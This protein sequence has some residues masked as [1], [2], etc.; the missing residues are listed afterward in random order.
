MRRIE[1]SAPGGSG[2]DGA[3]RRGIGRLT[4]LGVV[5]R[6]LRFPLYHKIVVANSLFVGLVAVLA[7]WLTLRTAEGVDTVLML[8]VVGASVLLAVII[9]ATANAVLV[10]LALSPLAP[11]EA[12]ARSVEQGELDARCALSPLADDNLRRLTTVFNGM[13]DGLAKGRRRQRELAIMVLEAEERE[14]MW[15][16]RELYDDTAQVLATTLL[17]LRAAA[18]LPQPAGSRALETVRSEIVVAMEG[19]RKVARRLRPPELDELGLA[20]AVSA[21]A[22]LLSEVSGLPIDCRTE[23]VNSRLT[24]DAQLTL[25]RI[26]QEALNNAVRHADAS[27]IDVSI[28][29]TGDSVVAE[30]SDDGKGFDP[31]TVSASTGHSFGLVGMR[32]RA[33]YLGGRV[34]V[35]SRPGLGTTLIVQ[36]PAAHRAA[37]AADVSVA[38]T[39]TV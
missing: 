12:T 13:L 15:L 21:H 23:A 11:I 27:H 1:G 37:A 29:A 20:A 33:G 31:T 36:I 28:R 7:A 4:D 35:R 24:T 16:S 19:V 5:R 22:R 32:E 14:R 2:Q 39:G 9:T 6:F 17:H 34:Q 38:R 18:R 8:G 10:R 30:I 26:V 25:Y 3:G